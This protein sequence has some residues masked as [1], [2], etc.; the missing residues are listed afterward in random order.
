M[1]IV[2]PIFQNHRDFKVSL[3]PDKSLV[4][5]HFTRLSYTQ[6]IIRF[7]INIQTLIVTL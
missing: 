3:Y 4:K 5:N 6:S 1:E 2:I 7:I